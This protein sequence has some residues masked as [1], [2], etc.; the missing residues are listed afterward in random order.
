MKL[1][2]MKIETSEIFINAIKEMVDE[3]YKD[4]QE[5]LR[6]IHKMNLTNGEEKNTI[7]NT[8]K[9]VDITK[10]N[11]L[12]YIIKSNE[13]ANL[14]RKV[15]HYT[16]MAKRQQAIISEKERR[17]LQFPLSVRVKARI[18]EPSITIN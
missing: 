9:L 14:S 1:S 16:N 15:L 4:T 11:K 5:S 17:K 8:E 12:C 18:R 2:E 10:Q 3:F 7:K 6:N 13:E